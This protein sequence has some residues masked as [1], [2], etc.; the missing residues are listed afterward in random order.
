MVA[1]HFDGFKCGF[2]KACC[3]ATEGAS[4]GKKRK[5]DCVPSKLCRDGKARCSFGV[6]VAWAGASAD[7]RN[8]GGGLLVMGEVS[9]DLPSPQNQITSRQ[10]RQHQSTDHL[11]EICTARASSSYNVILFRPF[12]DTYNAHHLHNHSQHE[13]HQSKA[14]APPQRTPS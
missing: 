13:H 2:G 14:I 12:D 6:L 4:E 9:F 3:E 10:A 5:S 1:Y 7:P 8:A 11:L